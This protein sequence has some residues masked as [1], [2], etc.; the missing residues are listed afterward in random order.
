MR[1][2][3]DILNEYGQGSNSNNNSNGHNSNRNE[4]PSA[5]FEESE[6]QS[7]Q[8][9]RRR[10]QTL[11]DVMREPGS[12]APDVMVLESIPEESSSRNRE[13]A[14]NPK[15]DL[16]LI[17][18]FE[19]A[20]CGNFKESETQSIELPEEDPAIFHYLIAFLYE[21]KYEPIKPASSVLVPDQQKG[22]GK[23]S[24]VEANGGGGGVDSENNNSE[25]SELDTDLSAAPA[26]RR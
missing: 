8:N 13:A 7:Q 6:D 16:W 26:Q 23:D 11:G 17:E 18:Y 14:L 1:D 3:E 21:G 22:K 15:E 20:L 24:S 19:K 5:N 9:T 2:I 10:P 25:D 12:R 4:E